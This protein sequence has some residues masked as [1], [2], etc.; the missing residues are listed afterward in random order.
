MEEF[1]EGLR[2][3]QQHTTIEEDSIRALAE[4]YFTDRVPG[5]F[6]RGAAR[7]RIDFLTGILRDY[8]A[9]AVVWYTLMYRESYDVEGHILQRVLE[10][11][12]IPVLFLSSDYDNAETGSFK[13]RIETFV[14]MIRKDR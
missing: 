14:D 6:F 2:N 5:A 11:L 12:G 13:T 1:S 3:Y 8:N 4:S 7:E 9:D 10:K